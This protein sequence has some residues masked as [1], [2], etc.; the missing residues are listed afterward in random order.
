MDHSENLDRRMESEMWNAN[1][2]CGDLLDRKMEEKATGSLNV[3][4]DC[5]FAICILI[6]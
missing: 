6:P 4:C 2:D 1:G 3:S 5:L